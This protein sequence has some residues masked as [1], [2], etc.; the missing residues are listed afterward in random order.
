MGAAIFGTP[1]LILWTIA[2][3]RKISQAAKRA[4]SRFPSLWWLRLRL[5]PTLQ[6]FPEELEEPADTSIAGKLLALDLRRIVV[7]GGFA[8]LNRVHSLVDLLYR[9]CEY[10]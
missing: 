2:A 8:M 9:P 5:V 6:L 1:C 3:S 10:G 7:F 4:L